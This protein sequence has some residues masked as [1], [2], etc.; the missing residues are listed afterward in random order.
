M[1]PQV[2]SPDEQTFQ[3]QLSNG[4]L[5]ERSMDFQLDSTPPIEFRR[6]YESG[7]VTP[8]AFGLGANHS[9]NSWLFSDGE[10]KLSFMEIIR[11]DGSRD[12][13]DRISPGRGFSSDVVFE[14]H[15]D[16]EEMYGSRMTWEVNRFK[17]RLR[18]GSW[19]TFLGC[20]DGRCYWDGYQ[21][22]QGNALH[23]TRGPRL[24]LLRLSAKDNQGIEFQSDAQQRIVD[25]V[26]TKRSHVSYTYSEDGCLTEVHRA[27]GQTTL[28]TY[29]AA[30]HM[31]SISVLRKG[32]AVARRILTNEY[33]ATGR[34]IRQTLA[35][36]SVYEIQYGPVINAH[37]VSVDLKEP[38]G[39]ILHL[40]LYE[41]SYKARTDS[42]KYPATGSK[43]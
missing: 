21:D 7:Y 11:E 29:D 13:L 40:H 18:D 8:M 36:G 14:S 27:D 12:H 37:A 1:I 20:N 15:D 28:Y 3:T 38:S 35:D 6:A 31:T 10:A 32:G 33:D 17:L 2:R 25:G 43:P 5:Y 34:I 22:A 30:H 39:R 26:D 16:A 42:I 24:Q 41:S 4:E 23:F 9:Y 19:S